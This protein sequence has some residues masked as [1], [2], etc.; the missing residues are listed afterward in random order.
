MAAA[1]PTRIGPLRKTGSATSPPAPGDDLVFPNAA[2]RKVNLND[3]AAGTTF[4]SIEINGQNYTITGNAIQLA[5]GFETNVNFPGAGETFTSFGLNTTLI[6][7]Q[8][9]ESDGG[10]WHCERR[11]HQYGRKPFDDCGE[12]WVCR[13]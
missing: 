4:N 5:H 9:F 10:C 7:P 3:F 13:G 8:T 11:R 2:V 6:N 12:Q 1:A